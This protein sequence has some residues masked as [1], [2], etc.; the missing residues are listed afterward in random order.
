MMKTLISILFLSMGIVQL[1]AQ[2]N[3]VEAKQTIKIEPLPNNF[4]DKADGVFIAYKM[5][6]HGEN[7]D[8]I[9]FAVEAFMNKADKEMSLYMKI[10]GKIIAMQLENKLKE[11]S[12]VHYKNRDYSVEIIE[13]KSTIKELG[14][15]QQASDAI[16]KFQNKK[17]HHR[18]KFLL[19]R[20]V[21]D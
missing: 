21:V 4:T 17:D 15:G 5:K 14:N 7:T 3:Y 2:I 1:S 18:L 6:E 20:I 19:E 11:K 10:N 8:T 9:T 13:N 12:G 16:F